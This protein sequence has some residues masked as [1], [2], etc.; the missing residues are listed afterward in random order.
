MRDVAT[1]LPPRHIIDVYEE[2]FN[3]GSAPHTSALWTA[4][5]KQTGA[6]MALGVR[7]LA[8]IWDAAWAAGMGAK[9]PGR[10]DPAVMRGHYEDQ[11]FMRSVTV[12]EI[13]KEIGQTGPTATPPPVKPPKKPKPK[14][15]PK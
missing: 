5:H 7:T 3:P 12:D 4:L 6:V 15:K 11:S 10:M 13:D 1:I 8:M 9:N 14:A 2:S